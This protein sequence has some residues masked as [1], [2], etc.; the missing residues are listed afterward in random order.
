MEVTLCLS[1]HEPFDILSFSALFA[2]RV[3]EHVFFSP[4]LVFFGKSVSYLMWFFSNRF[5]FTH[6]K[7]RASTRFCSSVPIQQ[8]KCLHVP[9]GSTRCSSLECWNPGQEHAVWRN[10]KLHCTT[11][12]STSQCSE[13]C[14]QAQGHLHCYT[15]PQLTPF[16]I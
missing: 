10:D 9:C 12:R 15:F 14:M 16:S 3:L 5:L 6:C 8:F 1:S 11:S 2:F 13:A 4:T 7:S